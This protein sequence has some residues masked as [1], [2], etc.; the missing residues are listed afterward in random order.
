MGK[1]LWLRAKPKT[2][3][4]IRARNERC[5]KHLWQKTWRWN[6]CL[7]KLHKI[8]SFWYTFDSLINIWLIIKKT[9]CEYVNI[10]VWEKWVSEKFFH[11]QSIYFTKLEYRPHLKSL[12]TFIMIRDDM[13]LC[14]RTYSSKSNK[15]QPLPLLGTFII[16]VPPV[17][18][19][20][21]HERFHTVT[22]L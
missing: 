4:K 17:K 2:N 10:S 20:N 15:N 12:R 6:V 13:T 11:F 9:A 21:L 5:L 22:K 19:T 7:W 3:L 16:S 18:K 1:N 14:Q 8:K